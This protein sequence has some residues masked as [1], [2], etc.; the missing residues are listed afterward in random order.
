[1]DIHKHINQIKLDEVR[2]NDFL[3]L[4]AN[5]AQMSDTARTFLGSKMNERYYMGGGNDN[6]IVDFGHF[7]ALGIKSVECLL[8]AAKEAAKEMLGAAAVNLNVLSGVHSMMC[9]LLSTTEPGE[10][11]MTVP[12]EYGGHFA[13][14]GILN[15]I[16][17]KQVFADFDFSNLKFDIEKIAKTVKENN[18]K[19]IYLDVSYYLNPHNLKEIREA[20]GPGPIIIY[21]ASHTMGLIMGKQFQDPFR[22]GANVISANTHKTLPGPHK[23]MIAFKD[24]A[25][26]DKANAIIDGFLY[27]SPHMIH[28]VPLAITLLEM[29]EFGQAYAK[30]IISNSNDL[31]KSFEDLGYEVRKANTG[32]YSEDHQVH[33]FID[34]MG[35]YLDLYKNLVKNN[36]STNFEGSELAGGRWFIR[37]GTQ[38]VTRRGMKKAEMEKIASLMDKALKGDNVKDQT[39][40]FNNQFRKIH[41]SFD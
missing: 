9:S 34:K 7:T 28:L 40:S 31:A 10:T 11:I 2:N 27:S 8:E 21:D 37:I 29:K 25:L 12:L 15:K 33:V 22:D 18:V 17:R 14:V 5:E 1:M 35:N 13:T 19:A 30:Q 39:V 16:G 41:Y 32:R 23:G 6:Y 36:I 24:K 20:I 38:E 4:T 26:S 3:H